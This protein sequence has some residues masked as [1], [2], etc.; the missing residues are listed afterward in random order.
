MS[1]TTTSGAI[2]IGAAPR[3]RVWQVLLIAA[4]IA[5]SLMLGLV[6][7]RATGADT[8]QV[9]P[10][11]T[12]VFDPSGAVGKGHAIPRQNYNPPADEV[13]TGYLGPRKF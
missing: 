8:T 6:I 12:A 9:R 13:A 7:G 4:A 3:V 1:A 10:E 11:T 2:Q 5:V